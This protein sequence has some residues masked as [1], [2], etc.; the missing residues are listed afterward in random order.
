MLGCAWSGLRRLSLSVLDSL[1]FK[2]YLH[3]NHNRGT[4]ETFFRGMIF[5]ITHSISQNQFIAP[6]YSAMIQFFDILLTVHLNITL[7]I[8]QIYAQNLA[9]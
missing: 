8:N 5:F 2:F 9:L 4:E 3:C 1:I 7:V 6:C